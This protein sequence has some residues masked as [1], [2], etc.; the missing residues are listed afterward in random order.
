MVLVPV[1]YP[2]GLW[3]DWLGE[4]SLPMAQSKR[5]TVYTTPI[6]LACD[7]AKA[8]LG[9]HDLAFEEVDVSTDKERLRE[10]VLM[11]GQYGVPV[12]RVGEKAMI[13]WHAGEFRQLM[14]EP[15]AR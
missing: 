11:T 3:Q 9:E 14:E 10:M 1:S 7:Q 5:I 13:G 6:C 8:Y 15:G 12:I 4:R 2:G